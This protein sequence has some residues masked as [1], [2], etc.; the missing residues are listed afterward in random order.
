MTN[1]TVSDPRARVRHLLERITVT[2]LE[3]GRPLNRQAKLGRVIAA[4]RGHVHSLVDIDWG[5]TSLAEVREA[6]DAA[7]EAE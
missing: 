5:T 6:L 3:T 7:R 4:A 2:S 1:T